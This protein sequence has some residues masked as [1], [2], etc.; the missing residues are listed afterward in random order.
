LRSTTFI[1]VLV[2]AALAGCGGDDAAAPAPRDAA[3]IIR[4]NHAAEAV[5]LQRVLGDDPVSESVSLRVDGTAAVR[6]GGGRGYWDVA[7]RLDPAEAERTLA[8]VRRAPFAALARSTIDPGGFGG[9]D[10]GRRYMLRRGR[11]SVTI[12]EADLP[13]AMRRLVAELNAVIDG[14]RGRILA[15][16]RHFS[17]SGVTGSHDSDPDSAPELDNSPATPLRADTT[18]PPAQSTLSC[19]GEGGQQQ[20]GVSPHGVAAG[21][22]V[23]DGLQR[24]SQGRVIRADAVVQPGADVTL[25]VAPADRDRAG[26]LYAAHWRG[27]HRL[28]AAQHT[29]RFEGCTDTTRGGGPARFPGG[30]VVRGRGCVTLLVHAADAEPARRRVACR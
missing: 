15:D 26:L 12:A 30:I 22:L 5:Y 9:N 18:A 21:P 24:G 11:A 8:L 7:V 2:A 23:L 13:P 29:V 14:D 10:N 27:P 4:A 3:D 16:D 28:A 1:A 17:A 19:Y 6:R 25:S 20:A